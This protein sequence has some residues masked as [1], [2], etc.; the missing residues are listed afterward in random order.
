LYNLF[1]LSYVVFDIKLDLSLLLILLP[2]LSVS[3]ILSIASNAPHKYALDPILV[4]I[5]HTLTNKQTQDV[6]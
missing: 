2:Y 6:L 4:G 3:F 1:Q 5:C